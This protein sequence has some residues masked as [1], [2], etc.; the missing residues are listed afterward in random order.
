MRIDYHKEWSHSLG[1]DMEYKVYGE[2]G[3]P[4][5]AVPGQGG[6]FYDYESCGMVDVLAPWMESGKIRLIC[7]DSIDTE[8]WSNHYGNPRQRIELHERWYHYIMDELLPRLRHFDNET[9]M[10]TGCSMG[11]FHAGNFFF[12]RPDIFDSLIALSGLYHSAYGFGSYHDDLTY[13]NSPQDF[14]PNIPEDHPWLSLYR[15]RNIILC[16][17]QGRWEEELLE[18]TRCMDEIL[19]NKGIPAWVDYWGYDVD[20]DWPWW[21][22]QLAYFMQKIVS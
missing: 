16:V 17:G 7:C 10:V 4:L 19:N 5:L 20:H 8:T 15:Q 21:R 12:R 14:I 22:K 13:A 6:R 2:S 3:R 18:S 11:A 9:F 1:R